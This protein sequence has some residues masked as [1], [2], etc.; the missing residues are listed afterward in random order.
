MLVKK[1]HI[2]FARLLQFID[3]IYIEKNIIPIIH[4]MSLF[5]GK[6]QL[7]TFLMILNACFLYASYAYT[8]NTIKFIIHTHD[9]SIY[10]FYMHL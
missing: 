6:K 3:L 5:F 8:K 2:T 4:L 1:V 9:G 10:Y 7:D